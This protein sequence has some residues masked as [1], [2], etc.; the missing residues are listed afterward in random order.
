MFG[1]PK[2]L[3]EGEVRDGRELRRQIFLARSLAS[4]C[5]NLEQNVKPKY[6]NWV[7]T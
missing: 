6:E 5:P 7:G 2:T 4:E 1:L 3:Q